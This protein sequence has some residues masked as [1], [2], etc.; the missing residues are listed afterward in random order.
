[1]ESSLF[2]MYASQIAASEVVESGNWIRDGK[3]RLIVKKIVFEKM[4][5]GPTFV[6]EFEVE[7]NQKVNV[8][9]LLTKEKLDVEP[10]APGTSCSQVV[11]LTGDEQA[12]KSKQGSI[13]S[14]I[15]KLLGA[16][17]KKVTP[18]EYIAAFRDACSP[19]QPAKGMVI[20]FETVRKLNK[21]EDDE[22]IRP[23]WT[24]VPP[25][26]DNAPAQVAERRARI[27]KNAATPA[28]PTT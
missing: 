18:A 27:E 10:N 22:F 21:K 7:S 11:K 25:S 8:F 17:P 26:G 13:K 15:C 20:D 12:I 9:S 3:G 14:F 5:G 2:D 24:H 4:N 28:A 16:D 6:A 19:A 1:M 23:Q